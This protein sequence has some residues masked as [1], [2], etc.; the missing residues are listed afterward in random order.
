MSDTKD[1]KRRK[2]IRNRYFASI[3][4]VVMVS[5]VQLLSLYMAFTIATLVCLLAGIAALTAYVAGAVE[6][7]RHGMDSR[8]FIIVRRWVLFA[9]LA[10]VLITSYFM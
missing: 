9:Y 5:I 7:Y 6:F 10:V 1:L 2:R 4:F 8:F 3:V